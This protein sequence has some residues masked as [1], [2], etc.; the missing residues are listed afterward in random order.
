[1]LGVRLAQSRKMAGLSQGQLAAAMGDRYDQTMISHVE[2]GRSGLL[3][4]GLSEAARV[5]GVSIDYLLGLTDD[6]RSVNLLVRAAETSSNCAPDVVRI[7]LVAAVTGSLWDTYDDT[8]LYTLPFPRRW[9][10]EQDLDPEKCCLMKVGS[11][12][13]EPTLPEGSTILVDH[14]RREFQ[15]NCI[16]VLELRWS[17]LEGPHSALAARRVIW[18]QREE[19]WFYIN[20]AGGWGPSPFLEPPTVIGQV[21]WVQRTL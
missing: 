5:L 18:D 20:D 2:T 11:K 1:M 15:G 13:M 17:D 3:G 14:G 21:R 9:L 4:D 6:P 10:D 12:F 19:D 7:P 16:Y 8:V